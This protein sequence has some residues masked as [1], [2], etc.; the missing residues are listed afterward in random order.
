MKITPKQAKHVAANAPETA[1]EQQVDKKLGLSESK[2]SSIKKK[3]KKGGGLR[4]LLMK[5]K[6]S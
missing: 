2:E 6:M 1:A 4:A 3:M 5:K